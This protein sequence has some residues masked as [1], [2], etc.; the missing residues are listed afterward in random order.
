MGCPSLW[1]ISIKATNTHSLGS[2]H[3]SCILV[4]R[5]AGTHEIKNIFLKLFD[6]AIL[7]LVWKEDELKSSMGASLVVQWLII[8]LPMQGTWVQSLVWEDPTCLAA[9]K[10]AHHN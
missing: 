10:P 7:K 1:T 5:T 8:L 4:Y 2:N 6:A 3:I 9:T